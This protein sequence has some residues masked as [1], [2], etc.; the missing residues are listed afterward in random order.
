[1]KDLHAK[2]KILVTA[3]E[4]A[5]ATGVDPESVEQLAMEQ[6]LK[7]L[8]MLNGEYVYDPQD[9]LPGARLLRALQGPVDQALLRPA[10]S[11]AVAEE[12]LL[13]PINETDEPVISIQS[14]Q[15]IDNAESRLQ[16]RT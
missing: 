9:L 8:A 14:V 5:V 11:V 10:G 16:Q 2:L 7:P 6:E 15:P 13:R 12:N 3:E 1:M 4:V